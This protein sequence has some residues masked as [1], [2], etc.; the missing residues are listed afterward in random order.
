MIAWLEVNLILASGKVVILVVIMP[1]KI[2]HH[3]CGSNAIHMFWE[4]AGSHWKYG[5]KHE[6]ERDVRAEPGLLKV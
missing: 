3:S 6:E 1:Y 5:A 4:S 2:V